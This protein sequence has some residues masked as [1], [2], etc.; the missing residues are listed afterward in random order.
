MATTTLRDEFVEG[1]NLLQQ[2]ARN[3]RI[4][5]SAVD[6]RLQELLTE[7]GAAY[8][9]LSMAMDEDAEL[10]ARQAAGILL[11]RL[12]QLH[13]RKD[14]VSEEERALVKEQVLQGIRHPS[15][16]VGV[17][18]S[19]ILASAAKF[20]WPS[21]WPHLLDEIVS[22]MASSNMDEVFGGIRTLVM[23]AESEFSHDNIQQALEIINEPLICIVSNLEHEYPKRVRKYALKVMAEVWRSLARMGGTSSKSIRKLGKTLIETWMGP[24]EALL[25]QPISQYDQLHYICFRILFY[26]VGYFHSVFSEELEDR[27]ANLTANYYTQLLQLYR[28]GEVFGDSVLEE[29]D[30]YDSDSTRR[31][32]TV[33][34]GQVLQFVES[35]LG[36]SDKFRILVLSSLDEFISTLVWYAHITRAQ[37]SEWMHS[38]V[39]FAAGEE[40]ELSSFDVRT[41]VK[42]IILILME[43]FEMTAI[44]ELYQCASMA[45]ASAVEDMETNPNWWK[46][47]E[48]GLLLIGSMVHFTNE[49]EEDLCFSAEEVFSALCD[50]DLHPDAPAF[51]RGRAIWLT[52]HLARFHLGRNEPIHEHL[53]VCSKNFNVSDPIPVRYSACVGLHNI[54]QSVGSVAVVAPFAS[55]IV[56]TCV[57][58]MEADSSEMEVLS[59]VF[60]V[61]SFALQADPSSGL[62]L[63]EHVA[64]LSMKIW[65]QHHENDILMTDLWTVVGA[66]LC[67]EDKQ[68]QVLEILHDP[69]QS[70]IHSV[71]HGKGDLGTMEEQ[72][73]ELMGKIFSVPSQDPEILL[74]HFFSLLVED[75]MNTVDPQA[76]QTGCETFRFLLRNTAPLWTK[77]T[78]KDENILQW[79]LKVIHR[80]ATCEHENA[81]LYSSFII[82]QLFK[83]LPEAMQEYTEDLMNLVVH[84]LASSH[85]KPL[86]QSM[87]SVICQLYIM[88]GTGVLGALSSLELTVPPPPSDRQ[89]DRFV[90]SSYA[91]SCL[92]SGEG[93]VEGSG[94]SAL[95]IFF[96]KFLNALPACIAAHEQNAGCVAL[97]KL[98]S[99]D[100]ECIRDAEVYE[101]EIEATGDGPDDWKLRFS[102]AGCFERIFSTLATMFLRLVEKDRIGKRFQKSL[103]SGGE[104]G[105]FD[106]GEDDSG[107]EGGSDEEDFDED[108]DEDEDE[109]APGGRFSMFQPAENFG[110][111]TD[112]LMDA[113]QEESGGDG[114]DKDP[115]F[116]EDPLFK[117]NLKQHLQEFFESLYEADE[118]LFHTGVQSLGKESSQLAFAAALG[119]S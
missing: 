116:L 26:Q 78:Y 23:L 11:L 81:A 95:Q 19:R 68:L 50:F 42:E 105:I 54:F 8:T 13:W 25:C 69:I 60:E 80:A 99:E 64:R 106:F 5:V 33:L 32:L 10:S 118:E 1:L 92:A 77:W 34:A 51:L 96:N 59:T 3:P 75:L 14:C 63:A 114:P 2:S 18:M 76:L 72:A 20:E 40:D 115:D 52:S 91:R 55:H 90:M 67:L 107:E 108:E 79:C 111:L 88:H 31:S 110:D 70:V 113:M 101:A 37:E 44:E 103:L 12:V 24:I 74:T 41:F 4:N 36:K 86:I 45:V 29:D 73:I 56:P 82:I 46:L 85:W 98:L 87:C 62:E 58:L 49:E 94:I 109:D 83:K 89:D 27:L 112:Y 30:G 93:V 119:M 117:M 102:S 57:H 15:F 6:A 22:L 7:H 84:T 65:H 66:L 39:G 43:E 17:T 104:E 100:L 16:H 61:L 53:E 35:F 38:A 48:A 21:R 9:L 97:T 71:V 47:R 28:E